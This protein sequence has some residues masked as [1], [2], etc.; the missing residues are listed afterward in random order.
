MA[1]RSWTVP[2]GDLARVRA[3]IEGTREP[4]VPRPAATVAIVRDGEH[5]LEVYLMRRVRQMAFA[6]GMHVFPGGSLEPQDDDD[7]AWVGRPAEWWAGAFRTDQVTARA[8]VRAA[9]RETFEE[10]GVLLAG[11]RGVSGTA[12]V[13]GDAW[14]GARA[15]VEAG[16]TTLG[17]LLASRGLVVR[18]DLLAPLAHW[19]TPVLE[20]RRFDTRFFLAALPPGQE[21][22]EAGS[23]ADRRLWIRPQ[24]VFDQAL[25][26][27]PPTAAVLGELTGYAT[28]AEAVARPRTIT[29]V[30]PQARLEGDRLVLGDG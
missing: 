25:A 14:E 23:E 11:A 7:S 9:V 2:P 4:V 18:A 30:Q 12:Q 26:V 28:V 1:L 13:S 15:A 20:P 29:T 16:T 19:I 24:D 21:A 5:G 17:E 3:V 27:M 10:S 22:R 8:L 6:A